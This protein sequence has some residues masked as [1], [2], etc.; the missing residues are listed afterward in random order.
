MEINWYN[1]RYG[2]LYLDSSQD[3]WEVAD[4][5]KQI[6]EEHDDVEFVQMIMAYKAE[7]PVFLVRKK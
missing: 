3:R 2:Y 5:A 6:E 1:D 4:I 7:H